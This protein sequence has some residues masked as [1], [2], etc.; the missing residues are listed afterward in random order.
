MKWP[1]VSR[2]AYEQ[3]VRSLELTRQ[4]VV[5]A[6]LEAR[7]ERDIADV[8]YDDLLAKFTALRVQGAVE[9]PKG[10]T[11]N[12]LVHDWSLIKPDPAK[13]AIA[14]I[15]GGNLRMR[16]IMLRQLDADRAAGVSEEAILQRIADGVPSDGVPS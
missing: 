13:E 14:A 16:Q 7:R 3:A 15:A 12:D 9:V 5:A 1:W 4:D 6:R 8:R 10:A 11:V 2:A